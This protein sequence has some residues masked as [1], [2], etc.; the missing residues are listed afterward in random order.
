MAQQVPGG[1][2]A[3]VVVSQLICRALGPWPIRRPR[4]LSECAGLFG[5]AP[6]TK[7]LFE[8]HD[9]SDVSFYA[10]RDR[11]CR[12]EQ[13]WSWRITWS[14]NSTARLARRGSP[15][16]APARRAARLT[17]PRR[18]TPCKTDAVLS[19]LHGATL[20]DVMGRLGHSTAGA[21]MQSQHAAKG[22]DAEIAARMSA[23]VESGQ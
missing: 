14:Q 10:W 17:G 19:V 18:V 20:P 12:L 4:I 21:A 13:A 9:I 16:A 5:P 7:D 1:L 22:R 15:S 23:S 11:C 8:R 2:P 6:A 3:P